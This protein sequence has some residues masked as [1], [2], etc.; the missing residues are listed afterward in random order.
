LGRTR[1]G[2]KGFFRLGQRRTDGL[3]PDIAPTY[4]H[5]SG[6]LRE[7]REPR[8]RD[9][10]G[11][12]EAAWRLAATGGNPRAALSSGVRAAATQ[13]I[14][15]LPPGNVRLGRCHKA[16]STACRR[17]CARRS[18]RCRPVTCDV[19]RQC[20]HDGSQ[21]HGSPRRTPT[22]RLETETMYGKSG[23]NWA[24]W[25]TGEAGAFPRPAHGG[26]QLRSSPSRAAW[27][28][29]QHRCARWHLAW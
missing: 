13:H 17:D 18:R 3:G 10:G 29:P 19:Q 27:P 8:S 16:Q 21:D 22:Q 12:T 6:N 2:G 1:D 26:R 25:S 11:G 7:G 15:N 24:A 23:K 4:A 14:D 28:L 20:D 9:A 5:R